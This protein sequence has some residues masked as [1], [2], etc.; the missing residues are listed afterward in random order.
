MMKFSSEHKETI[1]K[2]ILSKIEQKDGGISHG[3]ADAFGISTS[4]V[5]LYINELIRNGIIRKNGRDSYALTSDKK[6]FEFSRSKGEME[7]EEDIFRST[8]MPLMS[9]LPENAKVIW[10][11]AFSEMINNVI[12][13]SD[14]EHLRVVVD[15]SYLTTVVSI[16]DDGVGVFRKIRDHFGLSSVEDAI[17]ELSKG[18]LTT[19][20]AHHSGEGIFFTSRIMDEFLVWSDGK[21]Y[22]FNKYYEEAMADTDEKFDFGTA[23]YLAL[24]NSSEKQLTDVFDEYSDT[25][26]GF[27][28]TRIPLKNIFETAPI[29]RS[30]AKRLGSRLEEFREAEL[31]FDG[32]EYIGQGFAH[33][34]FCVFANAH[35]EIKLTPLNMSENVKKMYR[36]VTAELM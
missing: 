22:S 14:A 23:V 7:S 17:V 35:P 13:H 25:E 5:H 29:S 8:L 32:I 26:N 34:M 18:K 27:V 16:F 4:T 3:V 12:D 33:E 2:Y 6:F 9:E 1:I 30:Q 19:D 24:S 11:Y 28:K 21:A 10:H 20:R 15:M 31:D 36:H